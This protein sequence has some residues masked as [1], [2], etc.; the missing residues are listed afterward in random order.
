MYI[1]RRRSES[2]LVWDWGGYGGRVFSATRFASE[3][4]F[5]CVGFF[6]LLGKKIWGMPKKRPVIIYIPNDEGEGA[7]R[8]EK[9]Q[10]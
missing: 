6:F 4:A 10:S 7:E 2:D 5:R 3:L 8:H 9:K 1:R